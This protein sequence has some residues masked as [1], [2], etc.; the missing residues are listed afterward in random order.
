MV[1]P[2][3]LFT[4]LALAATVHVTAADNGKA[5]SLHPGDT[6]VVALAS[7]PSTGTGWYIHSVDKTVL[8][9]KSNTYK[10]APHKPGLVGSGG[11]STL[12]FV[13]LAKGRTPLLLDYKQPFNPKKIFQTFRLTVVVG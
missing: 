13:A 11:T 5:V 7:N 12:K 3:A 10:A 8:R 2:A 4:A 1:G 9:F 6:L